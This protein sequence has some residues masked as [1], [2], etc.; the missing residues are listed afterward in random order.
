M[1]KQ[2]EINLLSRRQ[3]IEGTPI[4]HD[5]LNAKVVILWKYL[6]NFSRFYNLF[7]INCQTELNLEFSKH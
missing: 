4:D 5:T 6:S 3:K 1:A 2:Q 7:L